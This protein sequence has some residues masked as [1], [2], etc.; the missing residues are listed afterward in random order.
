LLLPNLTSEILL[1]QILNTFVM[2][3]VVAFALAFALAFGL[4]LKDA[5]S[6]AA[7]KNQSLFDEAFEKVKVKK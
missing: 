4:G 2:G 6:K 1:S 7:L 5:V 3:L